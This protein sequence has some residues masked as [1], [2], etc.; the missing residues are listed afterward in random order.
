L[1]SGATTGTSIASLAEDEMRGIAGVGCRRIH[2]S[3][4]R[5][6]RR[7]CVA[8]EY[9]ETYEFVF[10]GKVGTGFD[11]KVLLEL[12]ARLKS[13]SPHSRRPSAC[14]EFGRTG[15]SRRSWCGSR[16]SSGRRMGKRRRTTRFRR[17]EP[18][19]FRITH[20]F[21]P[22]AGREF[23]ALTCKEGPSPDGCVIHGEPPFCHQ[24]LGISQNEGKLRYQRTQV[25]MIVGSNWRFR[26]SGGRQDFMASAYQI[27][28]CSTSFATV[29]EICDDATHSP[30][31]S[32]RHDS[33]A[34]D[35]VQQL[36]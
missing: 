9:F 2:R 3:A 36:W 27:R 31:Q 35:G 19:K 7:G 17:I 23:E 8:L 15:F 22:L 4:G 28:S 30:P 1:R 33:A 14:R 6:E 29:C 16:S 18:Q 25:T 20:P 26:N 32:D 5:T 34:C 24:L 11:T 13:R 12:R 10:A 21:H